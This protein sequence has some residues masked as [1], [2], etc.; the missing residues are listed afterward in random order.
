MALRGML[1]HQQLLLGLI[2]LAATATAASQDSQPN[3]S[4]IKCGSLCIPYPFGTRSGHYLD[5]SFLINCDNISGT[6]KPIL[7]FNNNLEVLNI[8]LNGELKVST[9]VT[10]RCSGFDDIYQS[11][12]SGNKFP[13]SHTRNKF[14]AIGCPT[15]AVLVGD[16]QTQG[17]VATGCTSICSNDMDNSSSCSGIGCCHNSIPEGITTFSVSVSDMFYS[18]RQSNFN[19]CMLS[20]VEEL[21][22]K[23]CQEAHR[24][25]T[26]YACKA[27]NST[28]YN[29]PNGLGYRCNCSSGF[30]GNPYVHDGCKDIDE[31]KTSDTCIHTDTC[32]NLVGG[33]ICS[34]RK[35]FK[36]DGKKY[37]TGCLPS[38][39]VGPSKVVIICTM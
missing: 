2:I 20:F 32:Q 8:S 11:I 5:E 1:F 6:L 14:T 24:N 9:S 29:S 3:S 28:C 22:I 13:I 33:F 30:Q 7:A 12:W 27:E 18:W 35:G 10:R 17:D 16:S 26:S 4:C 25:E 31:C 21:E 37:G 39:E 36:G 23:T 15:N 19:T 38:G 34:C